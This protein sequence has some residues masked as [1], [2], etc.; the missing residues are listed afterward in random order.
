MKKIINLLIIATLLVSCSEEFLDRQPEDALSTGAFYNNPSEIKAGLMACYSPYQNIYSRSEVPQYL[1]I[2][3]DDAKDVLWQS[4]DYLFKKN[5]G[6]SRPNF[7]RDHYKVIVNSNNIINIIENYTP[8]NSSEE[9]LVKV[10]KGEAKF[11]RALAY[12]NLVRLYGDVPK[13]VERLDDP[14]KAI[15]IG[16]TSATE[17]YN[18]VIIPD[19]EAAIA[20]CLKKGDAGLQGEEARATKGAAM[21]ILGKVYLTLKNHSKAEEVLKRLIVSKEAGEYSLLSD[22]SQIHKMDNKFNDESIFEINYN[23]SLG[24]PNFLFKWM[25]NENGYLYG[26]ASGGGPVIMFNLMEDFVE[27]NDWIGEPDW[28][29]YNATLDSGL[30]EGGSPELQPWPKKFTPETSTLAQYNITGTDYNYMV[31][32]YAD[33]LLMYGEALVGNNKA[34]EALPYFN[35]VRE[36]AGLNGLT[37]DQLDIDRILHE[38]RLELAFEGHRYFDLVRTDKAVEKISWALM[39]IVGYDA[40]I[41]TTEP[42]EEYQLLLPIPVGEI[43]KDASLNQNPGY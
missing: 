15:G 27:D 18:S 11:L 25:T 38:R 16:R 37:V 9:E 12:F 5:T 6:N 7:W 32:R 30:L 21:T 2:I 22:F 35:M 26:I 36:R 23:A 34:S 39:T 19:L 31:T 41:F 1:E 3:S 10:Y 24:Q 40:R 8:L 29:R 43:Q 4:N 20:D 13:I 17:I 33:A 14:T 28:T 42:I